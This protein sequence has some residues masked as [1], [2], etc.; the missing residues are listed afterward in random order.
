MF[1]TSTQVLSSKG[2]ELEENPHNFVSIEEMLAMPPKQL[3]SQ[4]NKY[5]E[6]TENLQKG[7]QV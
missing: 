7:L 6:T 3:S 4:A 2:W 1:K 5:T